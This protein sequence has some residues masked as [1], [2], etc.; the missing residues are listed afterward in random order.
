ME[1]TP[2]SEVN[3][4]SRKFPTFYGTQR[5]ISVFISGYHLSVSLTRSIQSPPYHAISFKI[6]LHVIH[7]ARLGLPNSLIGFALQPKSCMWWWFIPLCY[8]HQNNKTNYHVCLT[9]HI[10]IWGITQVH[11]P[12]LK[13]PYTGCPRRNGQNFG[14]MF[15][16]L[17][18]T[19]ITQNTYIQSWTVTEIMAKEVWNFDSCYSLI[20]YQIHIETGRNIWFL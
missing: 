3:D 15:L 16:M 7:P 8:K 13:K 1:Q 14:R 6:Y 17:N 19:D 5:L 20:D 2:S 11:V 9:K 10:F 18:Y 12:A 4:L